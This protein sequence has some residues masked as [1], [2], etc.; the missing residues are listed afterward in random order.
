MT[1]PTLKKPG[2]NAICETI[3]ALFELSALPKDQWI[4]DISLAEAITTFLPIQEGEPITKTD[5]NCSMND[6][7]YP[8]I[9]DERSQ[10]ELYRFRRVVTQTTAKGK[11]TQRAFY[12]HYS[13]TNK[14]QTCPD[15][16]NACFTNPI[17]RIDP[18]MLLKDK[19]QDLLKN[20][21][22]FPLSPNQ[23][24]LPPVARNNSPPSTS[25]DGQSAPS[26]SSEVTPSPV[27]G[28]CE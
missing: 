21:N 10:R 7:R 8:R 26:G 24:S 23:S 17:V 4:S 22:L 2:K 28:Q 27:R 25:H 11:V 20:R 15:D 9:G 3:I 16:D 18:A 5:L 14:H 12:F 19:L 6:M 13:T 1:V